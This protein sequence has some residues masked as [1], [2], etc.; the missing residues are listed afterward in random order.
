MAEIGAGRI[1]PNCSRDLQNLLHPAQLVN[2]M[3]S[4]ALPVTVLA[5][6]VRKFV[7]IG[8]QLYITHPK[9]KENVLLQ[10][11][12]A[13]K[14]WLK[15]IRRHVGNQFHRYFLSRDAGVSQDICFLLL[16]SGS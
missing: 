1:P 6:A 4:F 3:R 10:D 2:A 14:S 13:D 15:R 5:G 8:N 11:F 7:D 16:I 12:S 9:A